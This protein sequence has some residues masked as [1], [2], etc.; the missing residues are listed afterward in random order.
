MNIR[1]LQNPADRANGQCR[2]GTEAVCEN[3]LSSEDKKDGHDSITTIFRFIWLSFL[4]LPEFPGGFSDQMPVLKI[5]A[6]F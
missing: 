3:P 1:E 4:R 6:C 2:N 5:I